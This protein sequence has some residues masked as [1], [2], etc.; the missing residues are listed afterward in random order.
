[1][2]LMCPFMMRVDPSAQLNIRMTVRNSDGRSW[3]PFWVNTTL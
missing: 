2:R 1:M 3:G